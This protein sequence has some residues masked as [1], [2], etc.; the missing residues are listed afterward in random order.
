MKYVLDSSVAVK[1][2]LKEQFSDKA[3]ALRDD[4]ARANHLLIAPD[5]FPVEVVHALSKAERQGRLASPQAAVLWM[6]VMASPP[7]F[8]PSVSCCHKR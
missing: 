4:F 2:V 8:F 3:Q 5:V 7:Q 6:D 1:W